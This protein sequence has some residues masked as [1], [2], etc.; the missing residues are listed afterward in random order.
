MHPSICYPSILIHH[1]SIN[2]R[3]TGVLEG[4]GAS[5]KEAGSAEVCL[6]GHE[7]F[8]CLTHEGGTSLVAQELGV[9]F[10]LQGAWV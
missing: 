7:E 9:M 1:P 5:V 6:V 10:P 3:E 8:G 4:M 2:S